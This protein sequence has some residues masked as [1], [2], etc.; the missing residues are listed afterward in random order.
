MFSDPVCLIAPHQPQK[1]NMKKEQTLPGHSGSQTLFLWN[2]SHNFD[3]PLGFPLCFSCWWKSR[4]QADL[5]F[6]VSILLLLWSHSAEILF[7]QNIWF[8]IS[9]GWRTQLHKKLQ[10]LT[11]WRK[12]CRRV[13]VSLLHNFYPLAFCMLRSFHHMLVPWAFEL[14]TRSPMATAQ[15]R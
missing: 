13:T 6:N 9:H 2:L 12:F 11:S 4:H 3:L 7:Q 10:S 5:T 15:V 14:P 1:T 8:I